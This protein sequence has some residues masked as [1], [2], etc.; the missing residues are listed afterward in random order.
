MSD[1]AIVRISASLLPDSI[2]TTIGGTTIITLNEFSNDNKWARSQ[3]LV[4]TTSGDLIKSGSDFIAHYKL[5]EEAG[6]TSSA[7][8]EIQFL[9]VKHS[10]TSDG[11]V[12]TTDVLCINIADGTP[13]GSATGD[14]LIKPKECWFARMLDTDIDM[15]NAISLSSS[16]SGG[17]GNILA[18]TI[19]IADDGGGN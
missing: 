9:F 7:T 18:E 19:F 6:G 17:T 11:N 2:K 8:D 16:L 3:T 13:T 5:G 15:I 14:I 1:K 10:G 12:E 4:G